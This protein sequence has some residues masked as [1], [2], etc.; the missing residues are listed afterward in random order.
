[1]TE[2]SL[3]GISIDVPRA[4]HERA[5]EFW[6][7][8]FGRE[9]EVSPSYPEFAQL[10]D[11]TQGCYVLIQ[12]TGDSKARMHLD[13]ATTERDTDLDRLADAGAH[14]VSR[15]A[16]WAVMTDPS[17]QPFCLCPVGGCT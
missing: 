16:K 12:A 7:A 2:L 3:H 8:A 4:D 1:M 10:A 9:A 11:V 17:G 14:E 15:H 6:S 13:F 5:V